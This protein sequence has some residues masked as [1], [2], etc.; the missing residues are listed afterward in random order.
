LFL[1]TVITGACF[2]FVRTHGEDG[3]DATR[4]VFILTLVGIIA[5]YTHYFG[6]LI[7]VAAS[8][9]AAAVAY[10]TGRRRAAAGAGLASITVAFLP[11][12]IYHA[13]YM[14]SGARLSAWIADFPV[15]T[16][17]SW[18]LRL[19]L[20]G[21]PGLIGV[22]TIATACLAMSNFGAFARRNAA[23][24]V[25]LALPLL[26]VAEALVISWYAPVL[27]SRNL[28]VVLPALYLGLSSLVDFGAGRW[29]TPVAAVCF[30]TQ[31]LLMTQSLPWYY[32]ARTK[33]Q[34][35]ES[36]DF[37]LAQPGCSSG[38]IYVYGETP[39]Y[40]YLVKQRPYLE[41]VEIP[42]A[43]G[44]L[45]PMPSAADCNV[46][47]WAADLPQ[48]QFDA[49]LSTLPVDRSCLR[50]AAFYWAFVAWRDP[51]GAPENSDCAMA[52]FN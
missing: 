14:S 47:F 5:S 15:S 31:L 33:E 28:I 17:I 35:R 10:G 11:W 27:T 16:A 1:S 49:V 3:R 43:G 8:F 34:W 2:R 38:P 40:R 25:A 45:P 30:T 32:T 42:L 44:P 50:V 4:A 29:G 19:W 13:H 21:T 48:Q 9:T 41:L 51:S 23:C 39:N 26:T 46:L 7:A 36:A 52:G 37:V 6:F 22:A 20:S 18:F 24:Q 12:V